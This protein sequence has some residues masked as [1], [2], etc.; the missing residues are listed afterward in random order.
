MLEL[1]GIAA[2]VCHRSQS[3]SGLVGRAPTAAHPCRHGLD[4]I[5]HAVATAEFAVK[6]EKRIFLREPQLPPTARARPVAT[7]ICWRREVERTANGMAP[8]E[9]QLPLL[10]PRM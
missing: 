2:T 8:A 6:R 4:A 1:E 9:K 7:P 10:Y 5:V 3:C